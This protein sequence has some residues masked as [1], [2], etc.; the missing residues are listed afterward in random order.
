MKQKVRYVCMYVCIH[1]L[2]EKGKEISRSRGRR[3]GE[4]GVT[5]IEIHHV[6]V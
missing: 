1:T 5:M 4:W 2:V 6:C 3:K